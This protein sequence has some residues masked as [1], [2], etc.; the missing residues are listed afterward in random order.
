MRRP[1]YPWSLRNLLEGRP[2]LGGL[3]DLCG[4]NYALMLRLAP[5]L[6]LM[7]GHQ[8]SRRE[9]PMDLHLD[10]IEQTPY[11]SLFRL[12][13]RFYEGDQWLADP[14]ARFRAYHDLRQL[15]VLELRQK[16]LPLGGRPDL[17]SLQRKWQA[18]LFVS[19][20]LGYCCRQRYAFGQPEVEALP[21]SLVCS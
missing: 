9:E 14:D 4:E 8:V 17:C 1:Y 2:S 15:E 21:E 3:L 10:I 5:G 16:A 12:T 13:Y 7:Q 18:N 19:K 20:W 11:T 6:V